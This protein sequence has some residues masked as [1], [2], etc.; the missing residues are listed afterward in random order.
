MQG[1]LLKKKW[2]KCSLLIAIFLF[3][4]TTLA[5]QYLQKKEPYKSIIGVGWNTISDRFAWYDFSTFSETWHILPYPSSLNVEFFLNDAFS[6]D[7]MASYNNYSR[8]KTYN[9]SIAG[10]GHFGSFD[11]NFKLSLGFLVPKRIVD[12]FLY[13]GLSYTFREGYVN[14]HMAGLTAG[15]GVTVKF[16][17]YF[18]IQY[19][20]TLNYS[21]F[22]SVFDE[23]YNYMQHHLGL[24][25]TMYDTRNNRNFNKRKYSWISKRKRFKRRKVGR[26]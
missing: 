11:A 12:P 24:V 4:F 9:D 6:L 14:Q 1:S 2:L 20:N 5:Q 16:S 23:N 13:G 8:E 21:L 18:G 7:F 15:Y 19:R 22:P 3:S 25:V 10:A 17:K 26:M